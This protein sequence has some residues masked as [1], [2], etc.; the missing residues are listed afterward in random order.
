MS[1]LPGSSV[2]IQSFDW[3]VCEEDNGIAPPSR[4]PRNSHPRHLPFLPPD[5][6]A[7]VEFIQLGTDETY[8]GEGG[9]GEETKFPR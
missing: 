2:H 3:P 7:L 1:D 6:L 5:S 9:G 4:F 8:M